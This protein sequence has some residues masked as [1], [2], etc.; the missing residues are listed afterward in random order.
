MRS[1]LKIL[2]IA[3]LSF[4]AGATGNA[5]LGSF[6]S[7][8]EPTSAHPLTNDGLKKQ[9]RLLTNIQANP[10]ALAGAISA[11]MVNVD[12]RREVGELEFVEA[13]FGRKPYTVPGKPLPGQEN[14]IEPELAARLRELDQV[15]MRHAYDWYGNVLRQYTQETKAA[16]SITDVGYVVGALA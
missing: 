10:A 6:S 16:L 2:S 13:I 3:G 15:Q 9:V 7:Q 1:T 11:F 4:I 14:W 12:G 5:L 8:S